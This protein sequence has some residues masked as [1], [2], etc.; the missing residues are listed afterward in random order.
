[1]GTDAEVLSNFLSE[2]NLYIYDIAECQ[3]SMV[4][5]CVMYDD[6]TAAL[7]TGPPCCATLSLLSH[8]LYTSTS[9]SPYFL[10]DPL[11]PPLAAL[12]L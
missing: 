2:A 12:Y 10:L 3:G 5:S 8:S 6:V 4:N 11:S 7:V 9:L 1:M